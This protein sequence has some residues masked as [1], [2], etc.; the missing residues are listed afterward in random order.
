[1]DLTIRDALEGEEPAVSAFI[2]A[3]YDK[4]VAPGELDEG[5]ETFARIV[6]PVALASRREGNRLCVADCAGRLVGAL[7]VRGGTH[8]AL[9]FVDEAW[10]REGVG[11]RLMRHAFGDVD[12]WP[13]LTVNSSPS[14]VGAYARMGF[15]AVGHEQ[16]QRG[17]RF[18]PMRRPPGGK[19]G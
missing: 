11:R 2:R 19:R 3:V 7:E 9:L 8:V 4:Y 15:V 6:E 14:A 17:I 10:Q 12:D 13:P 5:R 18:T 16:V 1:M